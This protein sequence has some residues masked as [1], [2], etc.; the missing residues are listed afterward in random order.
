[1][2]RPGDPDRRLTR[3]FL[4]KGDET[5]FRQLYRR[6]TPAIYGLCLRLLG[7]RDADAQEVV[8][9]VWVHA[10]RGLERFE[11]RSSL[12]T[13]LCGIAVNRVRGR[14][15]HREDSVDAESE[16]AVVAPPSVIDRMDLEHAL[17]RLPDGYRQ[18]LVLSDVEG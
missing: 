11:W 17:A 13:W 7:G 18:V 12:R 2:T 10:A 15:R 8:Q 5:A 16:G 14:T 9:D 1:M 6:H 4:R 3:R